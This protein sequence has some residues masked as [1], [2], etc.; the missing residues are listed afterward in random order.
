MCRRLNFRSKILKVVERT[1]LL[2]M[3]TSKNLGLY[4]SENVEF[5]NN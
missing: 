4:T 5:D 3:K 2:R 1:Q